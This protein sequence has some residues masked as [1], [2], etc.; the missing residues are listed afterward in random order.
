MR[1]PKLH[2]FKKDAQAEK[3]TIISKQVV[4]AFDAAMNNNIYRTINPELPE[5]K[6]GQEIEVKEVP[7]AYFKHKGK[8]WPVYDDVPSQ[9]SYIY[10]DSKF[11]GAGPFTSY[12]YDVEY[13]CY[14]IDSHIKREKEENIC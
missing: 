8:I 12:P 10:I 1:L 2:Y 4:D 3:Y 9:Q 7:Y 13:F 5:L 14:E 6:E 11:Y